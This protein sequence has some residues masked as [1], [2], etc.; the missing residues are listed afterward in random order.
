MLREIL[1]VTYVKQTRN[2]I[3]LILKDQGIHV[4]CV[5][6]AAFFCRNVISSIELATCTLQ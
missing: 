4:I 3:K 1:N 6:C 5:E 2:K